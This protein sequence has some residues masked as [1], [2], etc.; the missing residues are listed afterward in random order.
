MPQSTSELWPWEEHINFR[1]REGWNAEDSRWESGWAPWGRASDREAHEAWQF[2][3]LKIKNI[4]V[5][6]T[7]VVMTM[8]VFTFGAFFTM[9][10]VIVSK[11]A[12]PGLV[13]IV[14]WEGVISSTM[15]LLSNF[16]AMFYLR[17]LLRLRCNECS[18][19][20]GILSTLKACGYDCHCYFITHVRINN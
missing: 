11:P 19:T 10:G 17:S 5:R 20:Y 16:T 13:I 18:F 4:R 15:G 6:A 9:L 2:A 7:L 14:V 1:D 8:G 3:G 12:V